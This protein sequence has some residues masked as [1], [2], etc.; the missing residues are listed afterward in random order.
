[1]RLPDI[2]DPDVWHPHRWRA[3]LIHLW[4]ADAQWTA[5]ADPGVDELHVLWLAPGPRPHGWT[6]TVM[7]PTPTTPTDTRGGQLV[8]IN[9]PHAQL[10]GQRAEMDNAALVRVLRA[11]GALE[12]PRTD[13]AVARVAA[14]FRNA[15]LGHQPRPAGITSEAC[16]WAA[17][18]TDEIGRNPR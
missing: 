14:H 2:D 17:T 12:A 13:T 8:M 3:T 9:G 5:P 1:M 16:E 10:Y 11:L 15:A 7:P 6:L 18:I 4:P